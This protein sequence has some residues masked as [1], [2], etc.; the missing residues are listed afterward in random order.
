MKVGKGGW[1]SSPVKPSSLSPIASQ[2]PDFLPSLTRRIWRLA[3]KIRRRRCWVFF[4]IWAS[5]SAWSS[6]P[7]NLFPPSI[8]SPSSVVVF[9]S[10]VVV[11]ALY[12]FF[13]FQ[14]D[15][16]RDFLFGFLVGIVAPP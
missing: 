4:Q 9:F 6:S 13:L 2:K 15:N 7:V 16:H 3:D 11:A 8:S 14:I 1:F 12:L 10:G 5:S